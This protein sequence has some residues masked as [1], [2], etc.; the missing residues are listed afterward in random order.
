[1]SKGKTLR[2]GDSGEGLFDLGEVDDVPPGGDIVP[3]VRAA[4]QVVRMLPHVN[5]EERDEAVHVRGVLV[6]LLDD[7]KF[8]GDGVEHQEGP[9]AAEDGGGGVGHL[10]LEVGPAAKAGVDRL[11]Q[12]APRGGLALRLGRHGR[13]VHLVVEV[14]AAVLAE[15]RGGGVWLSRGA[16]GGQHG[17]QRRHHLL[18]GRGA[19]HA[20]HVRQ[21][22]V[23]LLRVP[24][25]VAVV[26][27]G[28]RLVINL[29]L[30]RVVGV[31][32]RRHGVV[33]RGL[34]VARL[35]RAHRHVRR[36]GGLPHRRVCLGQADH[37]DQYR[38][39]NLLR[40]RHLEMESCFSFLFAAVS[41]RR[42]ERACVRACLWMGEWVLASVGS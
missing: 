17:G 11:R 29:G 32:K 28:H 15:G 42:C 12:W 37:R 35:V 26:V 18:D 39:Q 22:L 4:Q 14:A 27:E 20:R 5:A 33:R 6:G 2:R 23:H 1:M 25:E 19:V 40:H 13:K 21:R 34:D 8:T 41:C 3:T 24:G 7:G 10:L 30:E 38:R 9:A 16:G 36:C 31:G